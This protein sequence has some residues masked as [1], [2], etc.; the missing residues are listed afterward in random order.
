MR[1]AQGFPNPREDTKMSKAY[2]I[3][4]INWEWQT[5]KSLDDMFY[6]TKNEHPRIKSFRSQKAAREW[7]A[8]QGFRPQ[9]ASAKHPSIYRSASGGMQATI[10]EKNNREWTSGS[11]EGRI[12][13][14]LARSI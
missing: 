1:K 3:E 5:T 8:A 11:T 14:A 4:I 9:F 6:F 10:Y 7:L 2:E 12:R 13:S